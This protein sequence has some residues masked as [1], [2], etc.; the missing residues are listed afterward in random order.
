[1]ELKP[2]RKS[3]FEKRFFSLAIGLFILIILGISLISASAGSWFRNPFGIVD[4]V[5]SKASSEGFPVIPNEASGGAL[6]YDTATA[7]KVCELAGY[8]TVLSMDCVSSKGSGCGFFSC[9]DNVLSSWNSATGKFD[10]SNACLAGNTWISSLT[11]SDAFECFNDNDCDDSNAYTID[12]CINPGKVNSYCKNEEIDC[13][14]DSDCGQEGYIGN[15]YCIGGDVYRDYK[16]FDCNNPGGSGSS[17]SDSTSPKL[18]E[19]C[20]YGCNNGEC[21]VPSFSKCSNGV[22]D[23]GDGFIDMNDPGCSSLDDDDEVDCYFNLDCGEDACAGGSNYCKNNDVYQVFRFFTCNNAGLNS[24]FCSDEDLP[25][26]IFDCGEDF[27]EDYTENYCSG[28]DVYHDRVCY[29]KGCSDAECFSDSFSESKK[30]FD[31]DYGCLNGGCVGECSE[32]SDCAED[33]YSE[34]YCVGNSVYRN[35]HDFGCEGLSCVEDIIGKFVKNCDYGCDAGACINSNCVD[36]DL[37][38]YDNCNVG[39]VGDD[40]NEKDC[41]DNNA[42]VNP[43]AVEV[44]NGFD[45][46]CDGYVDE[47]NVCYISECQDGVDNDADNLIDSEDPGCW[48]NINDANSYN[49]DLDDES[50]AGIECCHDSDCGMDGYVG[51]KYCVAGD[52]YRDYKNFICLNAGLGSSDCDFEINSVLI[53]ECKYGCSDGKCE[54]NDDYDG[55]CLIS[56]NCEGYEYPYDE[57]L[58]QNILQQN[59][60]EIFEQQ[61][62]LV[63]GNSDS[64]QT[65]EKSKFDNVWFFVLIILAIALLIFIVVILFG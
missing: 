56:G 62:V 14:V 58:T 65:D 60:Q 27:C 63:L 61:E 46:D 25:Y 54:S 20:D 55:S 47:G 57:E 10:L 44:C 43:G 23:D 22:D 16:E 34:N 36:N 11:C 30:V 1:M 64:S 35:L 32:D 8:K 13:L 52:V 28:G 41:N 42:N 4:F 12:S 26:L 9:G 6:N 45:D 15:N 49:P 31:C 21:V 24:A 17:C 38:G 33:Y 53:D 39:E 2:L 3:N 59:N 37:D 18:I 51:D 5:N 48:D 7:K 19:D 50:S 29:D 40:G